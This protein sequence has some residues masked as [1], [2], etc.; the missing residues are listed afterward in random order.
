MKFVGTIN[1][2]KRFV[3][4]FYKNENYRKKVRAIADLKC[5]KNPDK[6]YIFTLIEE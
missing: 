6:V 4:T 2:A 3:A 1:Q 5:R